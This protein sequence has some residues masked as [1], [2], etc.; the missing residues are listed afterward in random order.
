MAVHD[1]TVLENSQEA[2]TSQYAKNCHLCAIDNKVLWESTGGEVFQA[3]RVRKCFK[4]EIKLNLYDISGIFTS[5]HLKLGIYSSLLVVSS[6]TDPLARV[7]CSLSKGAI[8]A[9]QGQHIINTNFV[10]EQRSRPQSIKQATGEQMGAWREDFLG[11][12]IQHVQKH[13]GR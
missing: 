12:R 13:R 6:K 7:P 1:Q 4:E 8:W 9:H 2:I 10:K 5:S 3:K 11:G